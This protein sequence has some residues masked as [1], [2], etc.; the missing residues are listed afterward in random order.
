ML[1]SMTGYGKASADFTDKTITV[2]IRSLNS[3]GMDASLRM[4]S[5][6]REKEIEIRNELAKLFER[7]KV[8]VSVNVE[9][10]SEQSSVQINTTLAEAYFKQLSTLAK[11]LNQSESGLMEIVMRMPDVTKSV[12]SA[13]DENDYKN[14]MQVFKAAAEQ[15][16]TFRKTEGKSLEVE[17][18]KRNLLLLNYLE[19][20]EK[21][22][23]LRIEN[24]KKRI[25]KNLEEFIAIEKIDKNRF[26]QELIYY[27][28][29]IDVT[30]EKTRLR[31]HIKHYTDTMK[32]PGAGR[33]LNF[34]AQEMGREVNTIGSKANDAAIQQIVVL[35][36]DEVEK[37]KEQTLNVL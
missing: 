21:T 28:E 13:L 12:S 7:G 2:E 37:I 31:T 4:P 36:K 14:F 33:K 27:L 32:E 23:P 16:T 11:K 9:Y 26:E 3:K 10:R 18:S 6:Y 24:I 30:E 19:Q 29:K 15:M 8:D 25:H 1:Q 20:I 17:F 34:I 5:V 22:D 35:M